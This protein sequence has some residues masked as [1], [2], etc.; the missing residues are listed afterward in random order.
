MLYFS[1]AEM[2]MMGAPSAT[3]PA[4]QTTDYLCQIS[5]IYIKKKLYWERQDTSSEPYKISFCFFKKQQE[6]SSQDYL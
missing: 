1:C 5:D 3:V 2:G 4:A 6:K